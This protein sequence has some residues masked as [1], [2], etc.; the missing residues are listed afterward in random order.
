MNVLF[1]KVYILCIG[2]IIPIRVLWKLDR[3]H[4]NPN[5]SAFIYLLNS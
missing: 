4:G 5:L 2:L 1:H 3:I